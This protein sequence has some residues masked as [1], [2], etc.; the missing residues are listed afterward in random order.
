[1]ILFF[2]FLNNSVFKNVMILFKKFDNS[3]FKNLMIL[4]LKLF[5]RSI[6]VNLHLLSETEHSLTVASGSNAS[7]AVFAADPS[8]WQLFCAGCG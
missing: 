6:Q 4:F 7:V 5:V 8:K 3:V 1:M 2:K